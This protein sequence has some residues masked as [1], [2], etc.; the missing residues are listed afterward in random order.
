VY[1]VIDF[2]EPLDR[3]DARRRFERGQF[4]WTCYPYAFTSPKV[5]RLWPHRPT[6]T[7]DVRR[8]DP[9]Q[10]QP[11]TRAGT[12][13]GEFLAITKFKKRLVVILS[14]AGA[15]YRDRAWRGGEFFLVAPVRSLRNPLTRE[16]KAAPKFVWGV[17]TYQYSSIFYLR[18]S[19]EFD[20]REAV[21]HLDR[22]TTLHRSWLL[23]P[24]RAHLSS[25]AMVCLDEWLRNYLYGK[26]R[27]RFNEDLETYCQM[28]GSDPKIRTGLFGR[29]GI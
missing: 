9:R 13:P 8:S 10:E 6:E 22:M 3:A 28:V 11:D 21:L 23:E 2:Y 7:L 20:I 1:K 16:Y 14:T 17:I 26:V 25:D 18:R 4:W 19:H 24:G 29:D 12:V 5:T 15:P 27:A